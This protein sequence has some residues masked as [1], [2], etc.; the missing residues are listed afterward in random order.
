MVDGPSQKGSIMEISGMI[1][2]SATQGIS[3]PMIS[4]PNSIKKRSG[5]H[6]KFILSIVSEALI[7]VAT[8]RMSSNTATIN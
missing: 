4:H 2:W 7:M 8:T 5:C 1:I 6:S 3:F